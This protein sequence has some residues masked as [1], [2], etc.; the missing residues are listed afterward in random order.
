MISVI[1]PCFNSEKTIERCLESIVNQT[2]SN[3]EIL[4][5]DDGSTDATGKIVKKYASR[6]E[7]IKYFYKTNEGVSEARNLGLKESKGEYISFVDSDDV[8]NFK[9][10]EKLRQCFDNLSTK[11]SICSWTRK[12][13][14][15]DP[16][17]FTSKEP[18][19]NIQ[20]LERILSDERIK[21][22]LCN[23][24]FKAE[25]INENSLKLD[26]NLHFMEDLLFCFS[27]IT[28]LNEKDD[29]IFYN[30]E[31]Y[32]YILEKSSVTASGYSKKKIT[33]KNSLEK[34]L[35]LILMKENHC[36]SLYTSYYTYYLHFVISLLVRGEF[37]N[38]IEVNDKMELLNIVKN[39][40]INNI[41]SRSVKLSVVMIKIN[42]KGYYLFWKLLKKDKYK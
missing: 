19:T 30:E 15:S 34:I 3:I 6:D 5:I 39:A 16:D 12:N 26:K 4:V 2:Y 42:F 14:S 38:K 40:K 25:I 29:I 28:S 33:G 8:I 37:E 9:M 27:Y 7:R 11:L 36:N 23:K 1:V 17:S 10:L 41:S 20:A 21:G 18:M 31:L 35:T 13:F 24:L 22:F 32:Q